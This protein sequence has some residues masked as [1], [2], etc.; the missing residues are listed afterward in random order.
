MKETFMADATYEEWLGYITA[1][2]NSLAYRQ[3]REAYESALSM[4]EEGQVLVADCEFFGTSRQLTIIIE[5]F[6]D[7]DRVLDKVAD[8]NDPIIRIKFRPEPELLENLA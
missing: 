6:I 7:F 1:V 3:R 2:S 5:D 8:R 4:L